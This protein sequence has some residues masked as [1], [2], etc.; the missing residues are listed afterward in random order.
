MRPC[1]STRVE[2][3]TTTENPVWIIP[4]PAG[5]VQAAKLLKQT[6]IHDGDIKNFLKNGK[7]DQV[8]A[9]VKSCTPNVLGDL[10]MN[11]KYLSCTI[12]EEVANLE[13]HVCENVNDEEDQYKLDEEALNLAF[14]EEA[15]A[16]QAEQEW[17]EK[18]RKEQELDE[19]HKRQLWGFYV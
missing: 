1:S 2:T 6:D 17:L 15:R 16:T 13:L 8:V 10:T 18:C 9:I 3:S 7:L 19:E 12:P 4:G 5:I 11:L 14:K